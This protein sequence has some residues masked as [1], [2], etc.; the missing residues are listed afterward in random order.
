MV[1]LLQNSLK[2]ELF[3][4]IIVFS[5]LLSS[6]EVNATNRTIEVGKGSYFS[7]ISEAIKNANDGDTIVV[8]GGVYEE[9]L[10][11]SKRISLVAIGRVTIVGVK[12]EKPAV[13][14]AANGVQIEGFNITTN[15]FFSIAIYIAK[16]YGSSRIYNNTLTS[17]YFGIYSDETFGNE[18]VSNS[19]IKNTFGIMLNYTSETEIKKNKI[20]N[21][22][23]GVVL[24]G[25][26]KN[27]IQENNIAKNQ[28]GVYL[29]NSESDAVLNNYMFKNLYGIYLTGFSNNATVKNN[30]VVN[31]QYGIFVDTSHFNDVL[32]NKVENSMYGVYLQNCRY[33]KVLSNFIRNETIGIQLYGTI[34]NVILNNTVTECTIGIEIDNAYNDTVK[35]NVFSNI[36]AHAI[37]TYKTT[38]AK[39]VE[40]IVNFAKNG[41]VLDSS[42]SNIITKN[43]L[44]NIQIGV[45][46]Y[47]S[48]FNSIENI[49]IK[50]VEEWYIR[51]Q[52]EHYNYVE[53]LIFDSEKLN[54][55]FLGKVAI[56]STTVST[57]PKGYTYLNECIFVNVTQGSFAYINFSYA[58]KPYKKV[59][60]LYTT[61]GNNWK[62]PGTMNFFE[63]IKVV[64][65]KAESSGIYAL[66]S[67]SEEKPEGM[68]ALVVAPFLLIFALLVLALFFIRKRKNE[69]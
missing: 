68:V 57:S 45:Y 41:I 35:E 14:I 34:N 69:K 52:S 61:D 17:A 16:G 66:F 42:S 54:F 56:K 62:K 67:Y 7:K 19:I 59:T 11:I 39:L 48:D 30:M 22:K 27:A 58:N 50:E 28:Y 6:F 65:V 64:A 3:F 33:N 26:R 23:Y 43:K 21:N 10:V 18:I 51:S 9:N 63:N 29:F 40:N 1:R 37:T 55:S 13:T 60:I 5:L 20:E 24:S 12:A 32:E 46:I 31:S 49:T 36:L 4:A 25:D 2:K 44:N 15:G 53:N 8:H 38:R 47:N